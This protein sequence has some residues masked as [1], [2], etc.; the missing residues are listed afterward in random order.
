MCVVPSV[1]VCLGAN[2]RVRV[3]RCEFACT[4]AISFIWL[5]LE[6]PKIPKVP[7]LC[8]SVVAVVG[9]RYHVWRLALQLGRAEGGGGA[10]ECRYRCSV[11]NID[12]IVPHRW[13][14][15]IKSDNVTLNEAAVLTSQCQQRFH[16]QHIWRSLVDLLTGHYFVVMEKTYKHLFSCT[17][18]TPR[19]VAP[20]PSCPG[21]GGETPYPGEG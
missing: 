7:K 1:Y 3:L 20:T 15:N 19:G 6:L 16:S 12:S 18:E 14:E 17:L 10:V 9:A 8:P 21:E 2:V 11:T 4:I 5:E 13:L